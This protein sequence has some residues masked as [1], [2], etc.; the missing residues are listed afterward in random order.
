LL[1]EKHFLSEV[2]IMVGSPVRKKDLE[3]TAVLVRQLGEL[4]TGEDEAPAAET[5]LLAIGCELFDLEIGIIARVKDD[6]FRVVAVQAPPDVEIEPGTAFDLEDTFSSQTI[7]ANG[8]VHIRSAKSAGL[9]DHPAH[10]ALGIQAYLGAPLQTGEK[11]YGTLSFSS[12]SSRRRDFGLVDLDCLRLMANWLGVEIARRKAENALG[13][14]RDQ[15]SRLAIQDPVT[16]VLNRRAVLENLAD[17]RNRASRHGASVGVF[18]VN[19]DRLR[20]INSDLGHQVGDVILREIA[21]RIGGSLRAYDHLGRF[22]GGEF[23]AVLPGCNIQQTAEIA[24]RAREA[25][26]QSPFAVNGNPVT[27]T[28]SFGVSSTDDTELTDDD[29]LGFADKALFL[30]KQRG[31]N[32]V[33]GVEPQLEHEIAGV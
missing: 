31:R 1:V 15:L 10:K 3:K 13:A 25:L 23:L 5:Q 27:A 22:G 8:P 9:T 24:E 21:D 32:V 30:A 7:A 26:D 29:L 18:L 11:V 17:E 28:G 33:R 20:H 2:F 6:S 16:G 4:G 14:T 19:V 12:R